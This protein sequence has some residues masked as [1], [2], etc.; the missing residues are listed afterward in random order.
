MAEYLSK[1]EKE[2]LF[3]KYGSNAKNTGSTEA[4]VALFTHRIKGLAEHL[5]ENHKDHSC[6]RSLLSLVGKRRKLLNYLSR[7]DI[8]KY[9]ELIKELGI[10]K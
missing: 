5:Q 8:N 6:R 7:K 10:R 1:Q 2:E 9:R 3:A 4:Q